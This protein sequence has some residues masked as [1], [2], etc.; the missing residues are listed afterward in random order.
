MVSSFLYIN[1]NQGG[2]NMGN[3]PLRRQVAD[4]VIEIF[5]EHEIPYFIGGSYRFDMQSD[6]S[7]IDLFVCCD[8]TLVWEAI[9]SLPRTE[10]QCP[11]YQPAVIQCQLLGGLIHLTIFDESRRKKFDSL[12][13]EHIQICKLLDSNPALKGAAWNLKR[14]G[15]KGRVLYDA[16]SK[17]AK[18]EVG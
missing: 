3:Y 11:P 5:D 4:T 15:V 6:S 14:A 17:V 13:Q 9:E 2:E 12:A 8:P 10:T 16:L 18:A 1:L 7:D